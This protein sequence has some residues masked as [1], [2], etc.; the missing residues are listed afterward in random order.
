M[1]PIYDN[2]GQSLYCGDNCA[3]MAT[4]H[5]DSIDLVVTSPPYDSLRTYKGHS[6]DFDG[7]AQQ[8]WRIIKPGG[9]VVWIVADATVDGSE[10]GSSMRQ[11]LRFME[12][13]F[14]LHDT[15]IYK[16]FNP[17]PVM[18]NHR[19]S[20]CFEFMYVFSRGVPSHGEIRQVRT[21]HAGKPYRVCRDNN[22]S[23]D[24]G[25]VST[26]DKVYVTKETRDAEN[27]WEVTPDGP[28]E[29][30]GH[31]AA[32]PESLARDHILSWS[33]PGDVVLDPFCGSGTTLKM[34]KETGRRGIG[35]EVSPE[36]CEIT[37]ARLGARC[38][39]WNSRTR[40]VII[41]HLLGCPCSATGEGLR[42]P[43]CICD[44]ILRHDHAE[45]LNRNSNKLRKFRLGDTN[46]GCGGGI[47]HLVDRLQSENAE[48]LKKIEELGG[49]P[50][51]FI[52]ICNI[53]GEDCD[54]G[55]DQ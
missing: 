6:W 28:S 10:T 54:C 50:K 14:N 48:L 55:K 30:F 16:K 47:H 40:K 2:E 27:I 51:P 23:N 7:V 35:I 34:A 44:E 52:P 32:F 33:N 29:Y 20:Q 13:G 15:M 31:P 21:K 36:Y 43:A 5:D 25:A 19:Y 26:K 45:A 18:S 4:C 8:L 53:C 1:L 12:I 17:I 9:V 46:E 24:G 42:H 11:A 39:V 22:T 38:F 3:V 49:R 41:M 37:Q